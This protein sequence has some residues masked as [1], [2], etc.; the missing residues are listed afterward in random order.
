MRVPSADYVYTQYVRTLG[1]ATQD[2]TR[3]FKGDS[4][5]MRSLV[6]AASKRSR[7]RGAP[8]TGC[9]WPK[10]PKTGNC[11]GS[12]G[13]SKRA[14]TTTHGFILE[15]IAEKTEQEA[16]RSD[17]EDSA[18]SRYDGIVASGK[19]ISWDEMRRYLEAWVEGKKTLRTTARKLVC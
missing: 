9:Y 18:N 6:A 7:P 11:V 2:A 3:D 4:M 17:F 14:G 13:N 19:T 12:A 5:T 15:A 10:S 16:L 8:T 1:V